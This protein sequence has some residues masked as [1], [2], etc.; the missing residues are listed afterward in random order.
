MPFCSWLARFTRR[1]LLTCA[2]VHWRIPGAARIVVC[3]VLRFCHKRA[4]CSCSLWLMLIYRRRW[5]L[6]ITFIQLNWKFDICILQI[7]TPPQEGQS[8][9]RGWAWPYRTNRHVQLLLLIWRL[10]N[11]LV[12][13]VM[14]LHEV[15]AKSMCQ[16]MEQLLDV[17]QEYP[18]EVEYIYKPACVPLKRC[19][20]CCGDENLECQPTLERNITLQV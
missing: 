13:L 12:L 7:S 19:S 18:G 15:W 10:K 4:L 6:I 1:L 14:A 8:K 5:H 20:G 11:E 2:V 3:A 17:E 16:P 9:G